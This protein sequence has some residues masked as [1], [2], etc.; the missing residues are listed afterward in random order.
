MESRLEKAALFKISWNLSELRRFYLGPEWIIQFLSRF[1]FS[2]GETCEVCD[3][4]SNDQHVALYS[5]KSYKV[6][7]LHYAC[8]E[9]RDAQC[10]CEL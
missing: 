4:E 7:D 5:F 3:R 8:I 10:I 9:I 2:Q 1:N 6:K